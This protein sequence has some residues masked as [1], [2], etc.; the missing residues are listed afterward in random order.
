MKEP[1]ESKLTGHV[2]EREVIIKYIEELG[3]DPMDK[4]VKLKVQHLFPNNG[5]RKGVK[6]FIE[7]NLQDAQLLL[8]DSKRYTIRLSLL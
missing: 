3:T 4:D 5:V 1:T 8:M 7:D 6:G 2:Y